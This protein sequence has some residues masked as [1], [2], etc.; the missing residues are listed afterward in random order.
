MTAPSTN[1]TPTRAGTS[2]AR[3]P[4]LRLRRGLLRVGVLSGA[5]SVVIMGGL[6]LQLSA[7]HDP[8]LGPKLAATRAQPSDR[9]RRIIKTQVVRRVNEAPPSTTGSAM[10]PGGSAG[11]SSAPVAPATPAAPATAPAPAPAP[12]PV[13]TTTS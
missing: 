12:A 8:A 9:P 3:P 2:K 11:A 1:Q 7:G 10:P 6:S 13:Q 5:A 4:R